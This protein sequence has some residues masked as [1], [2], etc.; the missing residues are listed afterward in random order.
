[1]AE[2]DD[3]V[4]ASACAGDPDS[5]SSFYRALSPKVF[6]YLRAHG[7]DD[8]EG[9]T[10][11]VF[12]QV[13]PR[14]PGLVGGAAG[15]RTLVFSVAHARVVDETRRRARRPVQTSYEPELDHRSQPSAEHEALAGVGA[16][17]ILAVL[18]QLGEEQR[19]V[20][21]LRVL[22]DLTL[23]QTADILGKSV[24]AVKQLQRRGLIQLRSL[25]ERGEVTL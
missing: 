7:A 14:L 8:P 5:L 13:I 24:G 17:G 10:N 1:M 18:D 11:E 4:V 20:V 25:V 12:L 19:S 21:T 23:E 3:G 9:L 22:G 16:Q 15:L 6:G 2:L